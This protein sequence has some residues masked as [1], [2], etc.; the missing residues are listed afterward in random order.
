MMAHDVQQPL[1]AIHW[2]S[3]IMRRALDNG[4][5]DAIRSSQETIEVA[6]ERLD[7]MIRDLVES[8]RLDVGQ[9]HLEREP[10]DLADFLS[11]VTRRLVVGPDAGRVRLEVEAVPPVLGDPRRLE[12]V[13]GNLISNALKYSDA[14]SEVIFRIAPASGEVVVS[15]TDRGIGIA[16]E[17]LPRL[18]ER[19]FRAAGATTKAEGLGLGL[20]ITS[21]LVTAHGGRLWVESELGKGSTFFV[22]LPIAPSEE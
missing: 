13:F 17:A 10:I 1:T 3:Q 9:L 2:H 19:G 15:V 12:R 7:A 21:Q 22:A 20:Y 14:A 18:F 6:T 5:L 8:A 11:R 4:N 16:P